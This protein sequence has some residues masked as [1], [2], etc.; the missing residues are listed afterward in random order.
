MKQTICIYELI[1]YDEF[2]MNEMTGFDKFLKF[3]L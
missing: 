1:N 3:H 2:I